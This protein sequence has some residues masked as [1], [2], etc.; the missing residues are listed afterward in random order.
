M[1]GFSGRGKLN[2]EI[3]DGLIQVSLLLANALLVT[4]PN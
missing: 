4:L 1:A 2:W 3:I